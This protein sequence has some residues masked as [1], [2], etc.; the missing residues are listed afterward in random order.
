M[1]THNVDYHLRAL[2]RRFGA[3]NRVQLAQMATV[4]FMDSAPGGLDCAAAG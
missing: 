4:H 1:T 3:R 2:R